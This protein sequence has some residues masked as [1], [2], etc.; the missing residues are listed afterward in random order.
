VLAVGIPYKPS[1]L[2]A[3]EAYSGVRERYFT[4]F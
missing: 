3:G 4:V 2:L 1:L